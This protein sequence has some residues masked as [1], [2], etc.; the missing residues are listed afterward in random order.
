MA[1]QQ[2]LQLVAPQEPQSVIGQNPFLDPFSTP[3]GGRIGEHGQPLTRLQIP[4]IN[5][6]VFKTVESTGNLLMVDVSDALQQAGITPREPVLVG[7]ED[8]GIQLNLNIFGV[9]GLQT[10]AQINPAEIGGQTVGRRLPTDYREARDVLHL[11][12]AQRT[13]KRADTQN[14]TFKIAELKRIA[15][16][17]N[18]HS[19][20]NKDVL[21]NRIRT[22][23]TD[24]FAIKQ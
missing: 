3:V 23:V 17:L 10:P 8:I 19:G 21:A 11:I 7:D 22:A 1:T 18:L 12:T 13:S 24:L 2:P 5:T 16:N 15:R 20:G 9:E 6:L 14:A 4:A